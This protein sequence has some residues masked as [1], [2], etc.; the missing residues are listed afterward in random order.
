MKCMLLLSKG[1]VEIVCENDPIHNVS[2]TLL[3]SDGA[4]LILI[5]KAFFVK[6]IS[7]VYRNYLREKV[8]FLIY[9]FSF[10]TIFVFFYIFYSQRF[11][12]IR[13]KTTWK[14]SIG[15]NWTGTST[16]KRIRT[17]FSRQ[18]DPTLEFKKQC[19][20]IQTPKC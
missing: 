10:Y 3:V 19:Q 11:S 16:R 12:R 1:L 13:M 4:E 2:K 5:N 14:N 20:L 17:I 8:S 15:S 7:L 6:H 9:F 18:E